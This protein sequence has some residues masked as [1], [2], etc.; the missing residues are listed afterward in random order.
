MNIQNNRNIY[1]QPNFTSIKSLQCRGLY[2]KYPELG[3]ELVET[4]KENPKAMDFCK[5]YDVDIVFYAANIG[6]KKNLSSIHIFYDNVAKSKFKKFIGFLNNT[7]DKVE[8]VMY[9]SKYQVEESLKESTKYLKRAIHASI[10]GKHG[11]EY[12]GMLDIHLEY[13]HKR[14]Q[15]ELAKKVAE[16]EAKKVKRLLKV[17]AQTKV[18][19]DKQ[20]LDESIRK[21]IEDSKS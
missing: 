6:M 13:A 18:L 20:E 21:L 3:K 7:K 8:L 12:G 16:A 5:K 9:G 10:G 1:N 11:G 2:K 14:M 19:Q 17:N 4:L 15:D